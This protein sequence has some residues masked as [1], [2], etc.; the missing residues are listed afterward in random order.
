MSTALDLIRQAGEAGVTLRPRLWAEGAERL[1]QDTRAALRVHEADVIRLLLDARDQAS[2][3]ALEATERAAIIG[4]GEHRNARASVPHRLPP[5]TADVRTEPTLGATC[6]CCERGRWW[7]ETV[8][9]SG[10][11]CMTCHPPGHLAAGQYREVA[12]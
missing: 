11:R 10:W 1:D 7:C 5:S 12:T 2:D 4:D 6:H 9:P 8:N 3:A